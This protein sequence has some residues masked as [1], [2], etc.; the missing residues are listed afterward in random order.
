MPTKTKIR[1][2]SVD[3]VRELL[4]YE[5][6][7]GHLF[8]I[9]GNSPKAKTGE[10]AGYVC[11][12]NGY[13]IIA[14]FGVLQ[15]AHRVAYLLSVGTWPSAGIDHINGNKSDNRWENLRL[16]NDRENG[17]N[18]PAN[19]NNKCGLKG[20]T[21]GRPGKYIAR[22]MVNRRTIHLGT[23]SSPE[24]AHQAYVSEA[25]RHQG[26]YAFHRSRE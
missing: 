18:R 8:W 1:K 4:R 12:H 21:T 16:A 19:K 20:V 10:P 9:A 2:P 25:E 11:K 23:F 6:D 3:Q 15:R 22:I 24:A 13:V 5:P 14:L 7:T 26:I 17:A